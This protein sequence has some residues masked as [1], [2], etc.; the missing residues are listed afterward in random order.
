MSQAKE[1]IVHR[2]VEDNGPY[3]SR[4][5]YLKTT[6]PSPGEKIF[7]GQFVARTVS[8]GQQDKDSRT[9]YEPVGEVTSELFAVETF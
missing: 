1:Y 6:T 8:C 2:E 7:H 9:E 5:A 3:G 4:Y